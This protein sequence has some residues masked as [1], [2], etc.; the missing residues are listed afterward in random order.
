M[1][2]TTIHL[3]KTVWDIYCLKKNT[4][5]TCRVKKKKPLGLEKLGE[6]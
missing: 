5:F 1:N 4:L 3:A 6:I 2:R